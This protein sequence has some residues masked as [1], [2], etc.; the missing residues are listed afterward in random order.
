LLSMKVLPYSFL[1]TPLSTILFFVL[2]SVNRQGRISFS[3][4]GSP[5]RP[6]DSLVCSGHC[7]WF[8]SSLQTSFFFC[9]LVL[10][11]VL[12]FS[13]PIFFAVRL[14]QSDFAVFTKSWIEVWDIEKRNF[15]HAIPLSQPEL[16]GGPQACVL[17]RGDQLAVYK[18]SEFRLP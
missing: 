4:R 12:S 1:F 18:F 10:I 8:D 5:R 11:Y 13:F 17:E 2:L 6:T 16:I 14:S 3:S 15:L 7:L 9:G